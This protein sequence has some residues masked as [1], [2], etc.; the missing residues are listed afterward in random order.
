[1]VRIKDLMEHE[2]AGDPIT[3]LKWTRRTTEKI[4]AE[5]KT[6]GINVSR[7]TVGKLLKEMG[8]SLRVNAKCISSSSP[9]AR[10]QQFGYI[11]EHREEFT[12]QGKPVVSVDTK[13][14]ELIGRFINS[15]SAWEN[16]SLKVNDHDFPSLAEGRATPYGIYDILA[17]RGALFVGTSY[18]TPAFAVDC[19]EQWWR[20]EGQA[21]YPDANELLIL[22][23]GG[24][25]NSCRSRV[26]KARLHEK[27]CYPHGLSVTVSHYPPRTSKWN[28][29]EHRLFSAIS[30]NWSGKPLE[31]FEIVLKYIL[32]TTTSTG[33]KVS[34]QL[35]EKIYEKGEKIADSIMKRLPIIKHP[36]LPQWNYTLLPTEM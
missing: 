33:L 25:S 16:E 26:W 15:G 12:R 1:M 10:D 32:T 27:L 11:R 34:A 13:K 30:R 6:I 14:K 36:L 4:A 7:N 29:I 23:D 24:G 18:D 21:R 35:V 2:T 9:A 31:S 8:Y 3:G 17:N 5:L 28:P 22:A 19:I 20:I